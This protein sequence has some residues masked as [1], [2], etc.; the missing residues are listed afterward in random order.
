VQVPNESK[1]L[2]PH[3][4]MGLWTGL[5]YAFYAFGGIEVSSAPRL[6]FLRR[7]KTHKSVPSITPSLRAGT[8]PL[9]RSAPLKKPEEASK[10][11]RLMLAV[12]AVIYIISLGLALLL[13]PLGKFTEA[14]SEATSVENP[15]IIKIPLKISRMISK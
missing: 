2:F 14:N 8:N 12:L 4:A 7:R 15:A 9:I 11:G 5:I 6:Q 10:S 3:G 13:V 1:D